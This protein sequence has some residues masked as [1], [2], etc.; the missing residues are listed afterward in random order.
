[1]LKVPVSA[2]VLSEINFLISDIGTIESYTSFGNPNAKPR[3]ASG[4]A[5][6]ATTL[7]PSSANILDNIEEKVVFPTP[8]L[9]VI[10]IF[11]LYH[12][13]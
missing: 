1:M 3:L 12:L 9:P 7:Y 5:S 6:T 2:A 8:P 10:A 11:I 13:L 4:S